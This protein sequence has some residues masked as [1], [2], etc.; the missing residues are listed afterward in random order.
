MAK[1]LERLQASNDLIKEQ[2]IKSFTD[3]FEKKFKRNKEDIDEAISDLDHI[4]NDLLDLAPRNA[5]DLTIAN[6]SEEELI[7]KL[8]KNR[9]DR[10]QLEIKS[11]EVGKIIEELF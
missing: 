5:D 6:G 8:V 1:L 10:R 7:Q 11:E 9:I 3:K 2:R 4:F